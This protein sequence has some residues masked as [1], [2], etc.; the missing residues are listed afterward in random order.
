MI[1]NMESP[2]SLWVQLT[3]QNNLNPL[4]SH[5]VPDVRFGEMSAEEIMGLLNK[6]LKALRA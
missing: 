6:V 5:G 3:K 2:F 1:V 4:H